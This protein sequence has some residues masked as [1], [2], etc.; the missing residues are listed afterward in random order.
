MIHVTVAVPSLGEFDPCVS[1]DRHDHPVAPFCVRIKDEPAQLIPTWR[2][3]FGERPL[4]NGKTALTAAEDAP[5][6]RLATWL[7]AGMSSRKEHAMPHGYIVAPG[8]PLVTRAAHGKT[9]T[10]S[11]KGFAI[12]AF[13]FAVAACVLPPTI[14]SAESAH[15]KRARNHSWHGYGF[16]PGYEP[17]AVVEWQRAR[18]QPPTFWYGGPGF[19]RG[20]WNGGGFG[21]C[22]TPTPIGPHWNC[23]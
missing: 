10:G 3:R 12:A 19:Y 15:G 20:R 5:M 23:G 4:A 13:V 11:R 17:P 14:T 22:W 1:F 16:L 7:Y 2:R 18:V 9:C 8:D 21:P 6:Y